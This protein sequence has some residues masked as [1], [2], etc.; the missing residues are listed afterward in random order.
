M[1]V[2]KTEIES[3]V[4]IERHVVGVDYFCMDKNGLELV[5]PTVYDDFIYW[6]GLGV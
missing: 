5:F 4:D 6:Q 2:I 3:D 1:P